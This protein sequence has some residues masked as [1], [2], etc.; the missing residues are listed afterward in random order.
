MIRPRSATPRLKKWLTEVDA[1]GE[2]VGNEPRHRAILSLEQVEERAPAASFAWSMLASGIFAWETPLNWA[3]VG[4]P[5]AVGDVATVETALTG[6][7]TIN[8]SSPISLGIFNIGSTGIGKYT[9]STTNAKSITF[10]DSSGQ[11]TLNLQN[12]SGDTF[13]IGFALN[14]N[15]TI[16][17]S[18]TGNFTMN[19]GIATGANALAFTGTGTQL[20][21][22][23]IAN[24][25][26]TGATANATPIGVLPGPVSVAGKGV[27]TFQ[28]AS[29]YHGDTNV[30]AGAKLVVT[31]TSGSA[32]GTGAVSVASGGTISSTGI[33][34]PDPVLYATSYFDSAIYQF[35]AN[36]GVLEATLNPSNLADIDPDNLPTIAGAAGITVGPDGN[37]YISS[38]FTSSIDKYDFATNTL[39]TFITAS[40]LGEAAFFAGNSSGAFLP[41]GL[42]FGSDG[43]LYVSSYGSFGAVSP[44]PPN[45]PPPPPGVGAVVRFD[46][47]TDKNG[48][49]DYNHIPTVSYQILATGLAQPGG[50][51]FGTGTHSG[52]IYV[53]NGVYNPSTQKMDGQV[54]LI[55]GALT[56]PGPQTP[57]VFVSAGTGGLETPSGITFGS[58]G[59]LYV[60]D[61]AALGKDGQVLK[62]SPA[63]KLDTAFTANT[64]AKLDHQFPANVIFD[65]QGR[66]LS[67]NLGEPYP[68]ALDGSIY[69][70]NADGTFDKA[71]VTSAQF[72]QTYAFPNTGDPPFTASGVAISALALVP[73]TPSN[74]P[75]LAVSSVTVNAGAVQRSMVTSLDVSFNRAVDLQPGAFTL[76]RIGGVN[77]ASGDNATVTIGVTT[78]S[79]NDRTV[80]HLTFSGVNTE[81]G[82]IADGK[83]K[84]SIDSSKVY[85]PAT[86]DH[87]GANF[88]SV[89]AGVSI[90]RLYGDVNGDGD[91]DANEDLQGFLNSFGSVSGAPNYSAA[92]DINSDGD[93]DANE[94]LQ[95]FLNNFGKTL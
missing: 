22:A 86:G 84:L 55:A 25:S 24:S 20:Y 36:T 67:A 40:E 3:N 16:T 73:Q 33:I 49:L 57:G 71:L 48:S 2:P 76:T 81:G 23:A 30:A 37:L 21:T 85:D 83:W 10:E 70:F 74:A 82:S 66:L 17:N 53:G 58:D 51:S 89:A 12:N 27:V 90:G 1:V 64:A 52:D 11:A 56:A 13:N 79:V 92:F 63:G 19:R 39:S 8:I 59:S 69:R 47:T 94:D 42:T 72:P 43:D 15:L 18:S 5:Q 60:S 54:L 31:N 45:S 46:I 35:D 9:V 28:A 77:G 44:P 65:A 87:L 88:D 95:G 78:T 61:T 80:A 62:F 32:T 68:P 6:D 26:S 50:L 14:S 75:A 7:E 38:Q 29:T 4:Y 93:V 34:A 91:V 41:S